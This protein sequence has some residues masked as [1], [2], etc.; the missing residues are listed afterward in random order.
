MSV[1]AALIGAGI[2]GCGAEAWPSAPGIADPQF[3]RQGRTV[4]TVDLLPVDLQ[5]WTTPGHRRDPFQL[6]GELESTV[7]G[8]A[9][10]E[11][12]RRGYQVVAQ[13]DRGG[14][15]VGPEGSARTAMAEEDVAHTIDALSGY[16]HAQATVHGGLL[17][18]FLPARLGGETRSDATLYIGGWAFA[19]KEHHSNNAGKVIGA[20]LI[21]GL[22]AVLVVAALAGSKGDHGAGGALGKVAEGAGRAAAGAAR[23]AGRVVVGAARAT[24]A[25]TDAVLRDPDLFYAVTETMEA[26]ARSGT[27]VE[28]YAG[29]PDYYAEGP[30]DGRSAMMFEMTLVDNRNG[31]TLWHARQ[32]F[33]ASPVRPKEVERAVRRLMAS[34]PAR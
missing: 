26:F 21:V 7:A 15:Y 13:I 17:V 9:T 11:L 22:I 6:A 31:R 27:H 32:R 3:L 20:I 16:G 8:V 2:A 12:A 24:V 33:P 25:V 30:H 29:R 1:A 19:G 10:A 34:L 14:R 18:P 5:V 4:E 23:V 28:I